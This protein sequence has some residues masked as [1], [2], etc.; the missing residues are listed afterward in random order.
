MFVSKKSYNCTYGSHI[1]SLV[2][3]LSVVKTIEPKDKQLCT[4]LHRIINSICDTKPGMTSYMF[5][6]L[7]HT[8]LNM[9][10]ITFIMY[11]FYLY[12]LLCMSVYQMRQVMFV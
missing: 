6:D 3:C 1:L 9:W 12:F 5:L 8:Y 2:F 4:A 10:Y 7:T 11:I